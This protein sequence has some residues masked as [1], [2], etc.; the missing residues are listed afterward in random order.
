MNA[1]LKLQQWVIDELEFD[2]RVDAAHIGVTARDGVVTLSGHVAH[3]AQKIAAEEA[4]RRVHGVRAVAQQIRVEFAF[5]KKIA[6]DE[7]AARV[8]KLLEWSV[9]PEKGRIEVTV[10]RGVVTLS[11]VVEW[12]FQRR[13]AEAQ[14]RRL[15]GVTDVV[16]DIRLDP[17]LEAGNIRQQINRALER[18]GQVDAARV[19]VDVVDARRIAL[20]GSVH[21]L[22]DKALVENA[23]WQV[24]GVVRVDN[25]LAVGS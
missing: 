13:D 24:P 14:V 11:G 7:I 1:D 10:E 9:H 2:P 12:E 3:Y 19:E 15:G 20:R 5:D 8:V 23:A 18:A 6:D 16:N 22:A 17:H 4:A 25:H 21:N